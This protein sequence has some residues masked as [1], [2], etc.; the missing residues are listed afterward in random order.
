MRSPIPILD[1]HGH[2]GTHADFPAC[3]PSPDQMI[4]VMDALNIERLA[5]TSTLACF[6]DCPR[7]N[8]EMA[9]TI[10]KYP[11]RFLGYIT[12]NPNPPGE[13]IEQLEKYA[14]LHSPPLIK[15]HPD[16]HKYPVHGPNYL[17]IWDYANQTHA[18][19]LVHTWDS[20]PNCGPLLLGKIAKEFPHARILMGH[21]GV[22]W[23][24]Y[25]QAIEVAKETSNTYL[26]ISGSQCHRT[27]I[28]LCVAEAG[29]ERVVFGSDMP[30]LEAAVQLGRVLTAQ[31]PDAA[32]EAILRHNFS[33]ILAET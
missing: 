10:R 26:D 29:A 6:N 17:P 5:I 27:A 13:A 8:E 7:G 15:L 33:R 9:E 14:W 31:I 11:N 30:Y 22:S 21:S 18:F 2:V 25:H 16:A 12:V 4:E 23:R 19:L 20:D 3:K 32:K 1:C 28:E 24:G